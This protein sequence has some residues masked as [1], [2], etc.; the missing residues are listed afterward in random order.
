M[1]VPVNKRAVEVP[2]RQ[3]W[4]QTSLAAGR[5]TERPAVHY[6]P[7]LPLPGQT[8]DPGKKEK[9]LKRSVLYNKTVS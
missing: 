9:A 8:G 6:N 3:V 7:S 2:R 5:V 4:Y 1:S